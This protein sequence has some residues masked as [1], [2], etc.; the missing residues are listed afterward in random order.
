[1]RIRFDLSVYFGT[2]LLSSSAQA[3]PRFTAADIVN[4]ASSAAGPLAP[5]M[6]ATIYGA[7][8]T[9]I[10]LVQNCATVPL[11]RSCLDAQ[12]LVNG[13]QAPMTF[14]KW[15]QLTFQVPV[16]LSGTSATVQTTSR[17]GETVSAVVTVSVA[18]TAPGLYTSGA[19]LNGTTFG[20]FF[21]QT[22]AFSSSQ[23]AKPGDTISILG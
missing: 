18:P 2:L 9:T 21:A 20:A 8:L 19:I 6:L 1:M 15:G 5:G 14:A 12:V 22:G 10:G 11:P 3:Q 7:E 23:P 17:I 13:Q 16:D 4:A